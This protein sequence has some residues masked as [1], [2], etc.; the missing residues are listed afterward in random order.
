MRVLGIDPASKNLAFC[1][2]EKTEDHMSILLWDKMDIT[3]GKKKPTTQDMIAEMFRQFDTLKETLKNVDCVCIENQPSLKNP[4]CKSLS[5]ALL[6]YFIMQNTKV[7]F[8]RPPMSKQKGM[9]YTQRKK[10]SIK[11]VTNLLTKSELNFLNKHKK[12]DDMCDAY[13]IARGYL[14]KVYS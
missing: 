11:Q 4:V 8:V 14:F 5:I 9:T 7:V 13:N 3:Q 2:L 10:A 12:K 6:S 1:L